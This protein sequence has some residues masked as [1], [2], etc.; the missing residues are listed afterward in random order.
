MNLLPHVSTQ[1]Y[2]VASGYTT[3]GGS[4]KAANNR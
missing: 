2:Q 1:P 3:F 4:G